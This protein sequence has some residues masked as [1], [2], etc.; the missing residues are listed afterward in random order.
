MQTL[1]EIFAPLLMGIIPAVLGY[2]AV[3]RQM[4]IERDRIAAETRA[5]E[6]E[7]KAGREASTESALVQVT[8]GAAD[9][10]ALLRNEMRKMA[11]ELDEGRE[12]AQKLR[13]EAKESK[14]EQAALIDIVEF[15]GRRSEEVSKG[16]Q[17]AQQ[18]ADVLGASIDRY[19]RMNQDLIRQ[20]TILINVAEQITTK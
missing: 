1:A 6:D 5:K 7:I 19:R 14:A 12:M 10:V 3:V 8:G 13:Q 2:L 17:Q 4:R 9:V 18:V 16:L 20:N 11:E 15:N